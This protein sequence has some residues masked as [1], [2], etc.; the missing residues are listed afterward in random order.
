M[1]KKLSLAALALASSIGIQA[2]AAKKTESEPTKSA[3]TSDLVSGLSFRSIGPAVTSGRIADIAVD[4][5][6]F[7]RY[8]VAAASGGVWLTENGGITYSPVFDSYGS[9][10]IG[11]VT[12]DSNN[13]NIVWVGTG[14]NNNQRSVAYG[15]G[16][17]KSVDG[18]KSFKKMGLENS[19]HIGM[20]AVHPENSDIVYVAAY[21]PLWSKGGDRGIYKTTNGGETWEKVLNVSDHTGFNEIHIDPSNPNILYAAA[22]QRRRHVYTYIS[23]GPESRL[24]KSTDGGA[25][26][27]TLENG[28]PAGDV[29]RIGMDIAPS[30]PNT[31]YAIVEGSDAAKGVYKSTDKGESWSKTNSY[32][33]SGNYYQELVVDPINENTIYFLDTYS[34][35]SYDGGTTVKKLGEKDKH[36]DNH[37]IWI[38]PTNNQHLL[39][40]CDGGIYES[41]DGGSNWQFH[42]NLPVTQFYKVSTDNTLPFYH[43]YG[44]TQDNFSL[45]GPSQTTDAAGI[46]N[47]DWYITHGGDGFETAVDPKNPNIVYAQSQYGWLVR[48]DKQTGEEVFIQPQP[49]SGEDAYRWNWDA[50]LIISPHNNHTLYFAANKLFKSTNQGDSWEVISADLT[51]QIDRNKLKVMDKSWSKDAIARHESTTIYGNIVALDESPVQKGLLYVGTDDGL[52][53]VSENDGA[54]WK[55]YSSFPGVPANTYVNALIADKYD[56]NTVYAV[57][58]NHKNGD[59]NPYI[60]KSTNKGASWVAIQSNLPERGSVYDLVQDHKNQNLLFAGTEFGVFFSVDAGGSWVQLKNG[61]PTVAARDLEIQ[62]RENDLVVASF[63]RGFYILDDYSPL[64][65]LTEQLTEESEYIFP[66]KTA[67][68]FTVKEKYGRSGKAFQGAS[69]FTSPNPEQGATFTYYIKD[70]IKT[71]AQQRKASEKELDKAGSD[72]PYP[73]NDAIRA[74]AEEEKPFVL[75][76]VLSKNN[77]VVSRFSAPMSTGINRVTWN[78][79]YTNANRLFEAQVKDGN[80]YKNQSFSSLVAPGTYKVTLAYSNNGVFQ[81]TSDTVAF[82]VTR[83]NNS[84]LTPVDAEKAFAFQQKVAAFQEL[85]QATSS[86]LSEAEKAINTY[87]AGVVN[88]PEL[89]LEVANQLRDLLPTIAKAKIMLDGDKVI[90]GTQQAVLPGVNGRIGFAIWYM[91][92]ST[93]GYTGTMAEQFQIAQNEFKPA[94]ELA[95]SVDSKLKTIEQQL[96]AAGIHLPGELPKQ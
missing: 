49:K 42:A 77:K 59:F 1:I 28:L 65:D 48:Y 80:P 31:L 70:A 21:G 91:Y 11:C 32:S 95:K 10:S 55:K 53:Q 72:I 50:P 39:M 85:A 60:L 78:C 46:T 6:N 27:R 36:V 18:G 94:Y 40:G 17:Y 2:V 43:V 76:T 63:G 25:T 7:N 22:H 82:E 51:Q 62:E 30:N 44:G 3:I 74:E 20:I 79:R 16:L 41:K 88:N 58:N 86:Y 69:F 81:P 34:H 24:Y 67:T 8:F 56:A 68:V 89:S 9:Y 4:P 35:V 26:W 19:E 47:A 15:D 29:G 90:E 45:G 57:F 84:T 12:I 37:T 33:T 92:S 64:R 13:P 23:G 66:V 96:V 38:N 75:F 93:F 52:I 5:T 54:S 71:K 83:L 61:Y 87:R 14:E 73:T